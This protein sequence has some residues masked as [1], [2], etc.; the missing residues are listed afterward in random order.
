M[1]LG[2]TI[3]TMTTLLAP[4]HW[5]GGWSRENRVWWG[6]EDKDTPPPPP[7][8]LSLLSWTVSGAERLLVGKGQCV[9]SVQSAPK[10]SLC[11]PDFINR[12]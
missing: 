3:Q 11:T 1:D 4:Q 8:V 5:G 7:L 12:F 6:A 9:P 2:N 10:P